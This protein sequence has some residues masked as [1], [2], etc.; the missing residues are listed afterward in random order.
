MNGL[1]YMLT[2]RVTG[3]RYVGQTIQPANVRLREHAKAARCGSKTR[4]AEAIREFGI[5]SFELTV[6]ESGIADSRDLNYAEARN[7]VECRT[8]WPD[9]YNMTFGGSRD[10]ALCRG[11]QTPA[12]TAYIEA[13]DSGMTLKEVG[14]LFGVCQ[15]TV[16]K[17]L[18]KA[19]LTCRKS[20]RLPREVI[21]AEYEKG[22]TEAELAKR[23]HTSSSNIVYHL[24]KAGVPRRG[25]AEAPKTK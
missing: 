7:I 5:D 19:G 11:R 15:G 8:Y 14:E 16:L 9:G 25:R 17:H 20:G 6:L 3:M 1:I 10:A 24:D 23:Y 13:Y 12:N 22:A 2:N 4:I 21:V 18:R